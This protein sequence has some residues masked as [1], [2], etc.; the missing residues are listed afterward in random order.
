MACPASRIPNPDG[1]A[2]GAPRCPSLFSGELS[3][4]RKKR[5]VDAAAE[6]VVRKGLEAP[7]TMFLEMHRPLTTLTS[8]GY[9]FVQPPLALM[10]GFWRTEEIRL[11]LSDPECVSEL[12][13]RIEAK[14]LERKGVRKRSAAGGVAGGAGTSGAMGAAG[15]AGA[16]GA[17]EVAG[18]AGVVGATGATGEA[19]SAGAAGAA[20]A[21]DWGGS[22]VAE[23][24]RC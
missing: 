10:F 8:V 18:A 15:S 6:W 16:R 3:E 5:L 13:A 12:L 2:T 21:G 20:G 19:G 24:G 7:A 17:A 22:Q 11:L 14:A 1:T 4:E 23:G 9:A